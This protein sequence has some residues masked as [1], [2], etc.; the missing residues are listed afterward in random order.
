MPEAPALPEASPRER[1]VQHAVLQLVEAYAFN[2]AHAVLGLHLRETAERQRSHNEDLFIAWSRIDP[3]H[4]PDF[5]TYAHHRR[6][7]DLAAPTTE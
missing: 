1:E 6:R 4:R 2:E 7:I 5:L 3:A